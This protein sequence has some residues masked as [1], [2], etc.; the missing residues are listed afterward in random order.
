MI[1]TDYNTLLY[2]KAIYTHKREKRSLKLSI[3]HIEDSSVT[4]D[5]SSVLE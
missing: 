1:S 5:C 4:L 3:Y 2:G